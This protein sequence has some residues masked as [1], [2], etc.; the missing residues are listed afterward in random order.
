MMPKVRKGGFYYW[1]EAQAFQN[2]IDDDKKRCKFL[3]SCLPGFALF[4]TYLRDCSFSMTVLQLSVP[5]HSL[6]HT[7]KSCSL[8][9]SLC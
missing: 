3:V 2:R 7:V 6:Y 9:F 5:V 1:D 4:F 8:F